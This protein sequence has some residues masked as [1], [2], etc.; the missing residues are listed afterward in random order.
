M[1]GGLGISSIVQMAS[2]GAPHATSVLSV[3]LVTH[4]LCHHKSGMTGWF[5]MVQTGGLE[6]YVADSV[7]TFVVMKAAAMGVFSSMQP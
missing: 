2:L 3:G 1:T 5:V 4:Q 7:S 6:N